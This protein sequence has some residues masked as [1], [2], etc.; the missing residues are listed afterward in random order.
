MCS[1]NVGQKCF[2]CPYWPQQCA[3]VL[4]SLGGGPREIMPG[5]T[6]NGKETKRNETLSGPLPGPFLSHEQ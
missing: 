2:S 5:F 3:Q 6:L 4:L 1:G